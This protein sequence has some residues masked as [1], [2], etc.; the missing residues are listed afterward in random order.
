MNSRKFS[1]L[2]K[3]NLLLLIENFPK[4]LKPSKNLD[5]EI[6]LSNIYF[7]QPNKLQVWS[8]LFCEWSISDN[9]TDLSIAS[10]FKIFH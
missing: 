10:L 6:A 3:F 4:I 7:V 9:M 5:N 1:H 2:D 8:C